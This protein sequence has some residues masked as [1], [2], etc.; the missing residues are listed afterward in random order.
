[1]FA[2]GFLFLG[3]GCGEGDGKVEFGEEGPREV[4]VLVAAFEDDAVEFVVGDGDGEVVLVL[5]A[6]GEAREQLG[7]EERDPGGARGLPPVEEGEQRTGRV[8]DAGV[9]G[10][11]LVHG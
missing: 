11:L 8:V 10:V 6:R 7:V 4:G 9:L 3:W 1:L 2:F 5:A